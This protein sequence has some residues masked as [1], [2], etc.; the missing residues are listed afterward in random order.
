M[1][2]DRQLK[3]WY[4]EFNRRWF[5]EGLPE[6]VDVLYAPVE[7]CWGETV[8]V[9]RHSF[10]IRI[11]PHCAISNRVT[12]MTLLHEMTHV[13]LW[14]YCTHGPRFERRMQEL[15]ACGAMRGLW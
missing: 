6:E 13:E 5:E 15:A 4:N 9:D 7:G 12:K 8:P 3:R 10:V 14:P 2:N 1:V 11:D